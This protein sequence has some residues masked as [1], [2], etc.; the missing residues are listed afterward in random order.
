MLGTPTRTELYQ[1]LKHGDDTH[2]AWLR[3]AICAVFDGLPVPPPY[4]NK[5][6][7]ECPECIKKSAVIAG[8]GLSMRAM[9]DELRELHSKRAE[10]RSRYRTNG[11]WSLAWLWVTSRWPRYNR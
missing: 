11:S 3:E 8:Q 1:A 9:N 10:P 7:A 5:K 2:Q 6:P 4:P